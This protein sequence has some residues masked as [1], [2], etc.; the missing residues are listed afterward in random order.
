MSKKLNIKIDDPIN[1]TV[2]DM[3]DKKFT[4][5]FAKNG[6]GK[7]T[8]TRSIEKDDSIHI[9]N[10]DYV[11]RNLY[12]EKLSKDSNEKENSI[13]DLQKI[14]SFEIFFGYK[15]KEISKTISEHTKCKKESEDVIK[16]WIDS[17]IITD[18][19]K[20]DNK[21]IKK[22]NLTQVSNITDWKP[23]EQKQITEIKNNFS[24]IENSLHYSDSIAA[25]NE[26]ISKLEKY[27]EKASLLNE[28]VKDIPKATAELLKIYN[29]SMD[30]SKDFTLS[31][32]K[33]E[34]TKI[35]EEF[36]DLSSKKEIPTKEY[37]SSLSELKSSLSRLKQTTYDEIEE[38]RLWAEKNNIDKLE[39]HD[40]K[41]TNEVKEFNFR[42]EKL[43]KTNLVALEE[44][45]YSQIND[46]IQKHKENI[47]PDVINYNERKNEISKLKKEKKELL[48]GENTKTSESI[49]RFLSIFGLSDLIVE[50]KNGEKDG[51][52]GKLTIEIVS[53]H[54]METLS[55]GEKKSFALSYYMA[56][57][58]GKINYMIEN[59]IKG[60]LTLVI[61]DPFDSNDH[62]KPNFFKNVKFK[63][64]DKE[65]VSIPM[66]RDYI[67]EEYGIK[68]KVVL[69]THNINVLYAMTSNC[70]TD[71]GETDIFSSLDF[72]DDMEIKEWIKT[73]DEIKINNISTSSF[74]PRE[75]IM[76]S[77][78]S[79]IL[80]KLI[81][82]N[83]DVKIIRTLIYILI[84]LWDG[85]NSDI[86]RNLKMTVENK[87][88]GARYKSHSS[89]KIEENIIK[90]INSE[91]KLNDEISK[92]IDSLLDS[93]L[94][95]KLNKRLL[96]S[97]EIKDEIK[98]ISKKL[99]EL[100]D[101]DLN[102]VKIPSEIFLKSSKVS[103]DSA[104]I[105]E[106]HTE[107]LCTIVNDAILTE[108]KDM[109]R[110]FRHREY[111]S[112]SIVAFG[113]EE[114]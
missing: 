57:I 32:N 65:K 5:I 39:T 75:N 53:S 18:L 51:T 14:N 26:F 20:I 72:Q 1:L 92:I 69:L 52:N 86:R 12:I 17:N 77:A 93:D 102:L 109:L 101:S 37:N 100:N 27:N 112:S 3:T 97:E 73:P 35:K 88:W 79:E 91:T 36:I 30:Y 54:E 76:R 43:T 70:I 63:I 107:R 78:F 33:I 85:I 29:A 9:Y 50:T 31:G 87:S 7:T 114:V 80:F 110:L 8:Y 23:L 58:E 10:S 21:K 4:Y 49:N 59:E 111:L 13:T 108:D 105:M 55:E 22:L 48:D 15:L 45:L 40:I 106:I 19:G 16:K 96:R 46:N 38:I 66:L 95:D 34:Q 83:G 64:Q 104:K 74:F 94:K 82:E 60:E 99:K 84:R 44:S 89:E 41:S 67:D 25:A 6:V 56:E 28:I 11:I 47:E 71:I 98:G 103:S 61:D 68:M 90:Y 62:S 113:I 2:S 81:K 42:F 24:K